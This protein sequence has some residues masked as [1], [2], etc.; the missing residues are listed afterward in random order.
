MF[1]WMWKYHFPLKPGG[2]QPAGGGHVPVVS[3]AKTRPCHISIFSALASRQTNTQNVH[4]HQPVYFKPELIALLKIWNKCG[5]IK[6]TLTL[7]NPCP[8][9]ILF[10]TANDEHH[11]S[12][13]SVTVPLFNKG[14]LKWQ[15]PSSPL[16]S[17]PIFIIIPF[18]VIPSGNRKLSPAFGNKTKEEKNI[19]TQIPELLFK[20]THVGECFLIKG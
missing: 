10:V 14:Y 3:C 7:T 4:F 19:K 16:V 13:S 9:I 8:I 15:P 11:C 18:S 20:S 17:Y 1:T 12:P 5:P 6:V 2:G